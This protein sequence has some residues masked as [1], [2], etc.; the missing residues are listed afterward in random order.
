MQN[1]CGRREY[2]NKFK[3]DAQWIPE[4]LPWQLWWMVLPSIVVAFRVRCNRWICKRR[5]RGSNSAAH[6]R[7]Q[8]NKQTNANENGSINDANEK[9]SIM[10]DLFIQF[11]YSSLNNRTSS[12]PGGTWWK[13]EE[14]I[15]LKIKSL[16]TITFL[17]L[18]FTQRFTVA[19]ETVTHFDTRRCR[20]VG[21]VGRR[22]L[23]QT[24]VQRGAVVAV[25]RRRRRGRRFQNLGRRWSW[26]ALF[27]L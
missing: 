7:H 18:H 27:V 17:L 13:K 4:C 9:R 23:G 24:Q 5:I 26:S 2:Q 11:F 25:V 8:W 22:R 15:G 1:R 6:L 21:N 12:P 10:N 16:I 14:Y 3:I 19:V 20:Q